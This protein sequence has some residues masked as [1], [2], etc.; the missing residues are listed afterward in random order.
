MSIVIRSELTLF[1]KMGHCCAG[2]FRLLSGRLPASQASSSCHRGRIRPLVQHIVVPS[3]D[4]EPQRAEDEDSQRISE[5]VLC[6]SWSRVADTGDYLTVSPINREITAR[7]RSK[8]TW[9]NA[10]TNGRPLR[11]VFVRHGESEGNVNR[12]I[13]VKV[14]DHMLHLTAKG[15]TQALDAGVRL[16]SLVEEES[17]RFTV[18]PYVR[19]LET[20]NGILRAWGE[21]AVDIPVREDVR[22]REQEYGNF[23]SPFLSEFHKEKRKF[24]VLYYRFPEGESIADCYDRASLFCESLYRSWGDNTFRN[25]VIVGHGTMILVTLMRLLRLPISEFENLDSLKNCE[26]VALERPPDDGKYHISFTWASGEDQDQRG[27]RRK[28]KPGHH[29][30]EIWDGNPDAPLLE[31]TPVQTGDFVSRI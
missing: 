23:D 30:I 19:A 4:L 25:H 3:D 18:S 22:I 5:S 20:V 28:V 1:I 13:T 12:N 7:R 17:I 21:R 26:F 29:E 2:G 16:K 14:P 8:S 9:W 10:Q 15:R 11:V 6:S 24:G 31:S 27:L